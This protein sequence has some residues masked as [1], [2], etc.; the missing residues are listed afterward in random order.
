M[1]HT[2][3]PTPAPAT[4]ADITQ[5][6][7]RRQTV[8][9]TISPVQVRQMAATLSDGPRLHDPA[10]APL[11]AGWH[12][13]VTEIHHTAKKDAPSGT[14]KRLVAA[15]DAAGVPSSSSTPGSM[16]ATSS[17]PTTTWWPSWP[18]PSR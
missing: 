7:G 12:C 14:A 5:W 1:S 6:T 18:R 4:A 17:M 16:T 11:P 3:S 9:D 8:V 15:L 13:E 10:G 2:A